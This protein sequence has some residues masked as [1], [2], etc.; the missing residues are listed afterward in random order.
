MTKEKKAEKDKIKIIVSRR[1][2]SVTFQSLL[3]FLFTYPIDF[4]A[5]IEL[6]KFSKDIRKQNLIKRKAEGD[7]VYSTGRK[8]NSMKYRYVVKNTKNDIENLQTLG[9]IKPY[10]KGI[11][12]IDKSF[13]L[14]KIT[15]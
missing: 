5:D 12:Q 1:L 14:A 11:F 9:I 8:W 13:S 7:L 10:K 6:I 2:G 3:N 4:I 15:K